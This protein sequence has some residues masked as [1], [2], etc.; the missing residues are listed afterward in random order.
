MKTNKDLSTCSHHRR[1]D[2]YAWTLPSDIDEATVALLEVSI[3]TFSSQSVS[4]R[5]VF[6]VSLHVLDSDLLAQ[7]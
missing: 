2:C 7:A 1:N 3:M 4:F 6:K 5:I